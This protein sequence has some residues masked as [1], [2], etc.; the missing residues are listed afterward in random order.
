MIGCFPPKTPS[1]EIGVKS[2]SRVLMVF[3]LN[4]V[5]GGKHPI[6]KSFLLKNQ[7]PILIPLLLFIL[8]ALLSLT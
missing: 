5:F 6:D 1:K 4:G 2:N 8:I 7:F 3:E